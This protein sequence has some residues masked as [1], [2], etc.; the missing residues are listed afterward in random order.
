[1]VMNH[2]RYGRAT[3]ISDLA[4]HFRVALCCSLFCYGVEFESNYNA[5]F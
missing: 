5:Q 3:H 2:L 1:M 4:S